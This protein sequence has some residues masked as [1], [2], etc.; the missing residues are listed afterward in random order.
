[1]KK[2]FKIWIMFSFIAVCLIFGSA[3]FVQAQIVTFAQFIER[4]GTQDFR[5]TNNTT[6]ATFETVTGGSEIFFRYSNVNG[7]PAELQG[8]QDAHLYS[9][10][11]TSQTTLVSGGNII[12]PFNNVYEIQILRDT[13]AQFGSGTRRNLLTIRF[14]PSTSSS[15]LSGSEGGNSA[16]LSATTPDQVVVF[17]SDFL[18]FSNSTQRNLALSFSS[19]IPT[20]QNGTGNFLQSFTAAG[21]GTIASNP[22]PAYSIPTPAAANISGRV[23]NSRGR[24]IGRVNIELFNTTSGEI[25]ETQTAIDGS[26]SFNELPAGQLYILTASRFRLIFEPSSM[27][28]QVNGDMQE[29]NFN[30]SQSFW[31]GR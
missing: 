24:G 20:L 29:I 28:L 23:L 27:P 25:I 10:N 21:S 19:V 30:V 1:M 8:F 12:Q 5:F 16:S 7:L 22:A 6:S 15:S 2:Q 13:P 3:Q 14:S 26:Y 9:S 11:I 4:N 17:T 31:N 18:N